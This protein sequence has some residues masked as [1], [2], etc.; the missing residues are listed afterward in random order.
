VRQFGVAANEWLGEL[1]HR[2]SWT[3][4]RPPGSGWGGA[5]S[6]LA[7]NLPSGLAR[8]APGAGIARPGSSG[9]ETAE[10][11]VWIRV[12]PGC[13]GGAGA[14]SC[15]QIERKVTRMLAIDIQNHLRELQAER[16]LA[17]SRG[18]ASSRA[19]MADL[20]DEIAEATHLYVVAGVTE[21]AL[22]RAELSGP[23]VG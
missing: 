9:H 10:I 19:Y 17:S 12:P 13:P 20:D 21:I 8:P 2:E 22:L 18:L 6:G 3:Q 1:G 23:K 4:P 5:R 7:A 15:S 11:R 14:R 16:L